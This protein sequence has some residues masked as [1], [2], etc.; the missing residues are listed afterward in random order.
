MEP[1]LIERLVSLGPWGIGLCL[2]FLARKEIIEALTAPRGDKAVESL[3]GE[4]NRQFATN[5][6]MFHVTNGH[7]SG[8]HEIMRHTLET[9]QSMLLE[10]AR[11]KK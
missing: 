9:M 1:A 11:G 3:L 4:M 2:L 7:L 5:M 8:M 6:E 10:I